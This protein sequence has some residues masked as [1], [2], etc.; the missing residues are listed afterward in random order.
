VGWGQV[1]ATDTVPD[2][3]DK[4]PLHMAVP[5][6]SPSRLLSPPPSPCPSRLRPA[7]ARDE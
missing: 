2:Y 6:H 3:H 7:V 4:T 1:K 5:S